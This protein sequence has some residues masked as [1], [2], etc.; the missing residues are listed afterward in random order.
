MG[1]LRDFRK[2]LR[3]K[4]MSLDADQA[5]AI[6]RLLKTASPLSE[7]DLVLIVKFDKRVREML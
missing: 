3:K 2:S 4:V 6:N 5:Q 1:F 7:A